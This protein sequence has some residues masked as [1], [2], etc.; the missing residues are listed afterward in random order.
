MSE[1]IA[2]TYHATGRHA[3]QKDCCLLL[4]SLT[5]MESWMCASHIQRYHIECAMH[6]PAC[7]SLPARFN[8]AKAVQRIV[9]TALTAA[10]WRMWLRGLQGCA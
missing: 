3:C 5:L 8:H 4:T 10:A 7:F 6:A 1:C 2:R 9:R